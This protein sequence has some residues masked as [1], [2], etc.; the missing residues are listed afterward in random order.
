M[1]WIYE[2]NKKCDSAWVTCAN[3]ITAVL[4][5]N[6]KKKKMNNKKKTECND[7]SGASSA[8]IS[9]LKTIE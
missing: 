4:K 3:N 1:D 9:I 6:K 5:K 7:L 2:K 8:K